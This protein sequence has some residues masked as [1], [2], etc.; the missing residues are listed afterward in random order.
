MDTI[1]KYCYKL[2]DDC[3]FLIDCLLNDGGITICPE[4]LTRLQQLDNQTRRDVN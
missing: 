3:K 4:C 1:C 2:S